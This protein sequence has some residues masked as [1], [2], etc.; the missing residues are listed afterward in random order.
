MEVALPE[1][2]EALPKEAALIC[3]WEAVNKFLILF[4]LS[5]QILL[6]ILTCLYLN[7]WVL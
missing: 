5:V 1:E 3:W 4:Y 6:Y 7:P 2:T